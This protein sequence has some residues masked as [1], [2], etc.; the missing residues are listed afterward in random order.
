MGKTEEWKDVK[1]YEGFYQVSNL[2]N[3]RSITRV[4]KREGSDYTIKGRVLRLHLDKHGYY[5]ANLTKD[6][7][8]RT[9]KVHR[10][11]AN[12]FIENPSNKPEVN[13]KDCN[14]KNNS[15]DNLEWCT[16]YENMEWMHRQGRAKRTDEWLEHL[17][18]SQR[19][20]YK[21]VVARH[22]E[23]G[24]VL[25]FDKL[26]EVRKLGFQPSCV[27]QCCQGKRKQHKGWEFEYWEE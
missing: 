5:N 20:T 19:K 4:I 1:G 22:I 13:H 2:G 16:H 15:V 3:V 27:C 25:R 26:N 24:V 18:E 7:V 10:L 9:V 23:T 11:V 21:S 14:P 6:K 12:A 17:H 8:H